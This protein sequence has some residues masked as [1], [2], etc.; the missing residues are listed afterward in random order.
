MRNAEVDALL[1]ASDGDPAGT[2]ERM[3]TDTNEQPVQDTARE[4]DHEVDRMQA[5]IADLGEHIEQAAKKADVTR[6][7]T[8]QGSSPRRGSAAG[9]MQTPPASSE[10]ATGVEDPGDPLRD[11]VDG[12][13]VAPSDDG[14][15]T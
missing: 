14:E 7:L 12:S 9:E 11:V 8:G 15:A 10:A 13:D 1:G 3:S 6:E 2:T 4:M 5:G